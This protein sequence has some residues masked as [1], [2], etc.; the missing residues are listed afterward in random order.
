MGT[1]PEHVEPPPITLIKE[2]YNGKSYKYFFRIKLC[3]DL[4]SSTSDLYEFSMYFFEHG[5]PEEFLLFILN[6][7]M[8]LATTGKMDMDENIQY[9]HTLIRG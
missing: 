9:L 4:S 2:T 1:N 5:D 8:A 3:R 6:F 7:N